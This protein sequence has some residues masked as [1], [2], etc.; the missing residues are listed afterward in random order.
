MLTATKEFT[1]DC[2]HRLMGHNG[3]CRNV[4]GHTYRLQV[5]IRYLNEKEDQTLRGGSSDGM[6]MDFK[7]LKGIV[8]QH[9]ISEYDHAYVCE[10]VEEDVVAALLNEMRMR[11][12]EMGRR[13]TAE[14]M[15]LHF[16]EILRGELPL[17]THL[18]SVRVWET[19]TSFAEVVVDENL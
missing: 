8:T 1:F 14:N 19:P 7:F 16:A 9:I 6:V 5:T 12:V 2:A 18:V 15:A 4:H 13:P 17:F 10:T 11:V 3:L